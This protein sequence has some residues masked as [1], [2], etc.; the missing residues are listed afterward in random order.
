[1]NNYAF[2]LS[3]RGEL[4]VYFLYEQWRNGGLQSAAFFHLLAHASSC[5]AR[6]KWVSAK[7]R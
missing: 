2:I 1:M 5:K 3:R 6:F 4:D 7:S